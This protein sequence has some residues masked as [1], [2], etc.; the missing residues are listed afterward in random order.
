MRSGGSAPVFAVRRPPSGASHTVI[1]ANGHEGEARCEAWTRRP[2]GRSE[3]SPRHEWT[4]DAPRRASSWRRR[5]PRAW[6]TWGAK[7]FENDA[8]LDWLA[9][10]EADGRDAL[11]A[12]FSLTRLE[13]A[14]RVA[15]A[16]PIAAPRATARAKAGRK[17]NAA[18][19]KKSEASLLQ[20]KQALMAFLAMRGLVATKVQAARIAG[21][22]DAAEVE[23]WLGR[24]LDAASVAAVLGE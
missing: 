13:A 16:A 15:G 19:K 20:C 24:A 14:A 2:H 12:A 4:S 23:R 1:G 5:L 11:R 8:A 9:G 22:T 7:T 6:G 17:K 18:P 3:G 21:S 10:L